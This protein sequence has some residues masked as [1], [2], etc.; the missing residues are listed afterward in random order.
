[1]GQQDGT[2]LW[3]E[4]SDP[5]GRAVVSA[6]VI[7]ERLATGR[8]WE[9]EAGLDGIYR[10]PQLAPGEYRLTISAPGFQT[11]ERASVAVQVRSP[12]R[13]DVRLDLGSVEQKVEVT[14]QGASLNLTDATMG[15]AFE[16][17]RIIQLPLE[18]RNVLALLSLQPGV[19]YTGDT[20]V[21]FRTNF[22]E[23]D[24]DPRNGAV[25]GG[26]SDQANVTLDG[27]DVND[28]QTGFPLHSALRV[29]TESIQEFR[30]TTA[31]ANADLG[32]SSGAQ[33]ALVTRSGSND[34]HGALFHAHRNTVTSANSFFNN[35]AGLSRAKLVRNTFG[36]ALGGAIV[37]NRLFYFGSYEGRRD[38]SET[39]LIRNVP[40]QALRDG[41]VTYRNRGGQIVTLSPQQVRAIDPLGI[42]ANPGTL[43]LMR[44]FPLP[45]DTPNID[46]LNFGGYRFNS[47]LRD[48]LNAGTARFD[49][50]HSP[51]HMFFTRGNLQ[52]D[53][54]LTALQF[55]GTVPPFRSRNTS[56]GIV[57]GHNWT[58]TA[59]VVNSLRYGY[60]LNKVEE[61]GTTTDPLFSFGGGVAAPIPLTYSRGRV[62][63]AHNLVNDTTWTRGRHTLQAGVNLRWLGNSRYNVEPNRA[64]YVTQVSRLAGR[65]AEILPADIA[66]LNDDFVRAAIMVMGVVSQGNTPVNYDASGNRIPAGT[67]L[68]RRFVTTEWEGYL[69]DS[70]RLRPTL[71]V[72]A[73]LRYSLY[74]PLQESTGLSVQPNIAVSDWAEM[75]RAAG[76]EGR[77][78]TTVPPIAYELSSQ[79]D[80][81][82]L[83]DWD[84]NNFA[85]RLAAAWAPA[86]GWSVRGGF[87]MHYDRVGSASMA[88]YDSL[89]SFGLNSTTINPAGGV[90]VATAPR[91]GSLSSSY[92]SLAVT[93][94]PFRFP[95]MYPR[96]SPG[97]VGAIIPASDR[98][99]RTP[100]SLL[101]NLSV[102]KELSGGAWVVEAAFVNRTS[103]NLLALFDSAM[104]LNLRDPQ[105]G[106]TY[107]EAVNQ[108]ASQGVAPLQSVRPVAYWENLFPGLRTTAAALNRANSAF[109]R[110]NPG[111]AADTVLT[112]SQ[113]AYFLFQQAN[114]GN[115]LAALRSIDV[116]CSPSCG[117]LGRYSMYNDQ[118][119]SLFSWRSIAPAS[120][121][122]MQATVRRRL[123]ENLT[124]DANYTLSRSRDWTSGA[125]R[126]DAFSNSFI[127]NSWMPEQMESFSD[128]DLRHQMNL[129]W[130][131]QLPVGNR[132]GGLFDAVLRGWQL[133]GVYRWS[134]GFPVNVQNGTGNPTNHYF[135][136][137]GKLQGEAPEMST[138][139][140]APG[141]PNLFADPANA[142][143]R[144]VAPA[145]GETGT[146]N[147]V[148]G[149]GIF[150]LDLGL[151]K[152]WDL[153]RLENHR[154]ELRWEVFNATN[155][156]RFNVRSA[157]LTVGQAGFGT[158]SAQLVN[159]RVMQFLLRY[160]F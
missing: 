33:I 24:T 134:S 147:N 104:P 110:L 62:A 114:P 95:L 81:R 77:A 57:I 41:S 100:Y 14:A 63:P 120:Y 126:G 87:G 121:N 83:Y 129:N 142:A 151:S 85:P 111:V 6:R 43:E 17:N 160:S 113:T 133:A 105:S 34:I 73:G 150:N 155:S 26:R 144:F 108:L 13:L 140:N 78:S 21:I 52:S 9:T 89:G 28:Q 47:P 29:G 107:F 131:A 27:V 96:V 127:I 58:A 149:D 32:R 136:G 7:A 37:K 146:R 91:F 103:R 138:N 46:P 23:A 94:Q 123:G 66:S 109:S 10:F 35:R 64:L 42:G 44:M 154:I 132:R 118:F 102:Q 128:F 53:R 84:R 12:R 156:V 50:H 88:L 4:I 76:Q 82:G 112:P 80:N 45:N 1:L 2:Y 115:A 106:S 30:V 48:E 49:Y 56:K 98:A 116:T 25:N 59:S 61:I 158:Y 119:A 153:P 137:F 15:L 65:G 40:T 97:L 3:G 51:R 75:R 139:K 38:A 71:T 54:G 130:I 74:A 67:P 90:S 92:P 60:L 22:G 159:P 69:Q 125:E 122:A 135:R 145:A 152:R 99:M 86:P 5:Q 79:R 19:T 70:W 16:G 143:T 141:G 55:P 39:T 11:V 93:P 8:Q 36:G 72:T 117:T 18:G 157:N 101:S 124:L 68:R 31:G 148:R 20:N